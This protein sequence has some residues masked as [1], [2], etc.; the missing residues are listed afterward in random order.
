MES[1]K[2]ATSRPKYVFFQKPPRR[3]S[4]LEKLKLRKTVRP[5][6]HIRPATRKVRSPVHSPPMSWK[7]FEYKS[8][9]PPARSTRSARSSDRSNMP[10][11]RKTLS[12]PRTKSCNFVSNMA[13]K[14]ALGNLLSGQT[15]NLSADHLG[16]IPHFGKLSCNKLH[17]KFTSV[18]S[19]SECD[20]IRQLQHVLLHGHD[21]QDTSMVPFIFSKLPKLASMEVGL[22]RELS[23]SDETLRTWETQWSDEWNVQLSLKMD[24]PR[25]LLLVKRR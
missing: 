23:V 18:L 8:V 20:V 13:A 7:Q 15:L 6:K 14:T 9:V 11:F 24:V 22:D 10:C 5:I 4:L 3:E 21:I 12:S 16:N 25:H 1:D 17:K 19:Y 2:P